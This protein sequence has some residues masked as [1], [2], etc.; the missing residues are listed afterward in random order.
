MRPVKI[1]F[2]SILCLATVLM[3]QSDPVD[4]STAGASQLRLKGQL[5]LSRNP[6]SLGYFALTKPLEPSKNDSVSLENLDEPDSLETP[7]MTTLP[8][9]I[10]LDEFL[11]EVSD[12]IDE[13]NDTSLPDSVPTHLESKVSHFSM[14]LLNISTGYGNSSITPNW[15]NNQLFGG[16][17]LRDPIQKEE[18]FSGLS[19]DISL[20]ISNSSSLPLL[21]FSFG[22]NVI[23]IGQA[24]SYT[25][26][27][28]PSG[29]AQFPFKG[30]ENGEE[31]NLNSLDIQHISY[32]PISYSHGFVLKPET[33]PV[34]RKSYMGVRA[35]LLVGLVDV[36]TEKSAGSLIGTSEATVLDMEIE[37][38]HNLSV[39]DSLPVLGFGAG[40]DIGLIT[41]IN[42]KL[43]FGLSIENIAATIS[44]N[45]GTI[46]TASLSGAISPDEFSQIAD[47]DSSSNPY[48]PYISQSENRELGNYKTAIPMA[49]NISSA[50]APRPWADLN[51][52]LK[53][54]LSDDY[55]ASAV[56]TLSL[57]SEL[58]PLSNLP[59]RIGIALGGQTGF[60]WGVGFSLKLGMLVM[61]IG[62]GQF[63][64]LFNDATGLN[65]G[66]SLRIEK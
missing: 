12:L 15:I 23:S 10:F 24:I 38:D 31:L 25:S 34:G 57:S 65:A 64:G 49:I 30:L 32:V 41:E 55:W 2:I 14:S 47:D 5:T 50:Y 36:H 43:M 21:N 48:E 9:D 44:W 39:N 46:Y 17:D 54:Y 53:L 29:L 52:N 11:D 26:V 37:L 51:A 8:D 42:D 56:P 60:I 45:N 27:N 20:F 7:L 62:G 22:P 33:I 59:F 63:G 13:P 4:I 19:E 28:I 1:F 66:F 18:F 16:K 6:A 61:D 58:F 35:N 3:G 40:L